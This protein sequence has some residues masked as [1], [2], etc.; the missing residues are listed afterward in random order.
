MNA[1]FREVIAA[2]DDNRRDLFLTTARRL[3]TAVENVEKDFWVCWTLDALVQWS[4]GRYAASALS[5]GGTSLSKSFGLIDRFSEDIDITVLRNDLGEGA[6]VVEL[7]IRHEEGNYQ[8]VERE[9]QSVVRV[10]SDD[11]LLTHSFWAFFHVNAD[12]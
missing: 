4:G 1:A 7:E 8:L 6:S 3:G 5:K 12:V 9:T 11:P 2:G 10:V